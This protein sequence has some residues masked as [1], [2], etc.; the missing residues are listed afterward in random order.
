MIQLSTTLSISPPCLKVP[1]RT[2]VFLRRKT[3]AT[4][5]MAGFLE[6]KT[7]ATWWMAGFLEQKTLAT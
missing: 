3:L 4:W 6:Q 7:L 1:V 5:W 2:I